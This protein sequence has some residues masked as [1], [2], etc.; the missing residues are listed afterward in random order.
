MSAGPRVKYFPLL[1]GLALAVFFACIDKPPERFP[2]TVHLAR[3]TCGEPGQPECLSCGSCHQASAGEADM[4]L[5][6]P[7]LCSSCHDDPKVTALAH[8]P[9][10]AA[11]EFART[12][13]FS[14]ERHLAMPEVL[15]QCV[16]CH[17]GAAH[18][19]AN[20]RA[21]PAMQKCFDCHEHQEQWKAGVCTP[22]H[23]RS[24][25]ENV[26]PVTFLRHDAGF[27][28][29]HGAAARMQ[30]NTCAQC[31]TQ[32]DCDACHDITQ[33]LRVEQ[34]LPEQLEQNFVH[35][36]DYISRHSIEAEADP[37][38]CARCHSTSSCDDCHLERGVSSNRIGAPNPHPPGWI[39]SF[40]GGR[41]FH[42]AAARRDILSCA[43]C[44]DQGPATNCISCHRVGAYGG[45]PHPQGW[46]SSRT[47]ADAMCRYC[48][49]N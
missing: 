1:L 33:T 19:S 45:N 26:L 24:D 27:L 31:H 12:I 15:G 48:H 41:S 37:V 4:S 38:A 42:G 3:Q 25:I 47:P 7:S 28:R 30:E 23:E 11:L 5:P 22:C 44:H 35:R 10:S 18:G 14:H 34:R 39:G 20:A 32:P 9:P 8:K 16:P 49:E 40:T 6:E 43:S 13:R 21:F 2:H 36:A 17:A 46:Q 29:Q